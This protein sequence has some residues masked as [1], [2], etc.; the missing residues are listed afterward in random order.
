MSFLPLFVCFVCLAR[1]C[2]SG[3]LCGVRPEIGPLHGARLGA[4]HSRRDLAPRH[5]S[6][7]LGA[8]NAQGFR[9][10]HPSSTHVEPCN[11]GIV[12]K[13]LRV[14][15]V[16]IRRR[17]ETLDEP[18]CTSKECSE[19]VGYR[20]RGH[21]GLCRYSRCFPA[22]KLADF[23]F[24]EAQVRW[25]EPRAFQRPGAAGYIDKAGA[26]GRNGSEN[27]YPRRELVGM[28]AYQKCAARQGRR[29]ASERT[30]R[31]KHARMQ[32][33]ALLRIVGP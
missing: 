33:S 22:E 25:C 18:L 12:G 4:P 7:V 30:W 9:L 24:V 28:I 14:N 19:L 1:C 15:L 2:H 8:G 16:R 10:T 21:R 29:C 11:V 20:M 32:H 27:R 5:Q 3:A 13:M 23:C 26:V 31:I 6:P 17:N